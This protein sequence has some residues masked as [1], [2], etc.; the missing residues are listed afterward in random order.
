[1]DSWRGSWSVAVLN[2]EGSFVFFLEF[3]QEFVGCCRVVFICD[4]G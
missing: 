4:K 3:S 2:V 1:M